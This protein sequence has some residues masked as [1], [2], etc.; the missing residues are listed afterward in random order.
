[1]FSLSMFNGLRD[2]T[3]SGKINCVKCHIIYFL[4]SIKKQK[5]KK[6]GVDYN[7]EVPFEKKP[8]PG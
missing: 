5:K 4:C 3:Y 6:R 1:M 7:A 8:A 2:F